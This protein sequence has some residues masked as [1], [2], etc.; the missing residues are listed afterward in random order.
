M[1]KGRFIEVF[2]GTKTKKAIKRRPARRRAASLRPFE[3]RGKC[4]YTGKEGARKAI[5]AKAY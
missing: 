2:D 4:F 3:E 1:R 5:F